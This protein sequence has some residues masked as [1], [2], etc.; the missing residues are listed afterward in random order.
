MKKFFTKT[1]GQGQE[2]AVNE[3]DTILC[4]SAV[5]SGQAADKN[6][7]NSGATDEKDSVI[8]YLRAYLTSGRLNSVH[9][10]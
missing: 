6:V 4:L 7:G 5:T 8:K 2:I 9:C 10:R 1:R 3:I